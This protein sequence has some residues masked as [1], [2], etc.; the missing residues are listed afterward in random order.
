M[1]RS[2]SVAAATLCLASATPWPVEAADQRRTPVV[3]AVETASP[4][5]VNIFTERIV[6][7]PFR[8]RTPFAGDPFFDDFF[9]DFFG[10]LPSPRTRETRTSLGSG[11]IIRENGTIVTNE[12]VI[13]RA[14]DIRVLMSDKSEFSATL[15]GADSDSDLAVLMVAADRPLPVIPMSED[16]SLLIG[17]TVIAIGNPYGLSH[18]VTTGVISATCRRIRADDMVYHDFIQTDAS[19][20]PGNSGGPLINVTGRLIGINTAIHRKAEGIGFAI[21]VSR[22]RNIVDQII[23][24]GAV[25]PP[26]V[27]IQVQ[28]LTPEL[29]FHFGVDAGA[30]ALV[31]GVEQGSPAA[32]AGVERGSIIS[33]VK[34]NAIDS[35]SAYVRSTRGLTAGDGLALTLVNGG[36]AVEVELKVA[37]LP[38]Q[39]IDEFAW[40]ALGLAAAES[41]T[42]RGVRVE[43]VRYRGPAS[44]IGIKAG[45]EITAL[46]G[47]AVDGPD[48]FRRRLAAFRNSNN[49]LIS[50]VRGRRLYRVTLPLDKGP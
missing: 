40:K 34:G 31:R 50:V 22:V 45:D 33:S 28:D 46:G 32:K 4:A 6:E 36:R 9:S 19:I 26:W 37:A 10:G 13:V 14:T 47:R 21:P 2:V 41:P 3:Q 30:G 20:N 35:A 48:S 39:R 29:A 5:V 24:F 49:V 25:Q 15:S 11:V 23:N 17:E 18:T 8:S 43:K 42:G 1:M 38:P 7:T 27:G 44:E 12:H 16:D